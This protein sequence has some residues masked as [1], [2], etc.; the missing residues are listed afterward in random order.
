MVDLDCFSHAVLMEDGAPEMVMHPLCIAAVMG[1]TMEMV[2]GMIM[3]MMIV[4]V[5]VMAMVVV[6]G[7]MMEMVM[8]IGMI[9]EMVIGMVME[10]KMVIGM[11]IEMVIVL[12]IMIMLMV[13]VIV[14]VAIRV[15]IGVRRGVLLALRLPVANV[16][17]SL[18]WAVPRSRAN[19]SSSWRRSASNLLEPW[20]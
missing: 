17:S 15:N 10:M 1:M 9:M 8:V 5:M 2:I 11:I 6:I 19:V 4:I 14:M 7:M 18:R 20:W 3:E 13:M 16:V 12:G